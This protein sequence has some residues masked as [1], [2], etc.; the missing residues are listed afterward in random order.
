MTVFL[1]L[2]L[3]RHGDGRAGIIGMRLLLRA[4]AGILTSFPFGGSG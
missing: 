1:S 2:S 3:L 4:G